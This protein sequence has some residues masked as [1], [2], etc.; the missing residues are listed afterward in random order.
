M[1]LIINLFYTV[2]ILIWKWFC[3]LIVDELW[4]MKYVKNVSTKQEKEKENAR[5][6]RAKTNPRGEKCTPATASAGEKKTFGVTTTRF[7][8]VRRVRSAKKPFFISVSKNV[9]K[10]ATERNRL[11][12]RVRTI[13]EKSSTT[14]GSYCVIVKPAARMVSFEELRRDLP[15]L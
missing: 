7:F 12:R 10:K 11:K 6:P 9:A 15:K 8:I 13:F 1:Y 5:I 3:D 14:G 2:S 4:I